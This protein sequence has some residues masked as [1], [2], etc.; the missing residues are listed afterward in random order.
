MTFLL[1]HDV[2]QTRLQLNAVVAY[3]S[4]EDNCGWYIVV[5]YMGGVAVSGSGHCVKKPEIFLKYTSQESRDKDLELLDHLCLLEEE[6]LYP[7]PSQKESYQ[8]IPSNEEIPDE[9]VT[10]EDTS[11]ESCPQCGENAW[12]GYICH[13]CGAKET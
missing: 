5:T 3:N 10:D 4:G 7:R 9:K 2:I 6:F 12:D 13:S 11:L 8:I 1:L